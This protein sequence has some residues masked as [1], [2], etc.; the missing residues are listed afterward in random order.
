MIIAKKSHIE[1][2]MVQSFEERDPSIIGNDYIVVGTLDRSV[3]RKHRNTSTEAG[4]VVD[5][6][7]V[8]K[9]IKNFEI[10]PGW[11]YDPKK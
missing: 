4:K 8:F 1:D 5:D 6:I 2:M 10:M 3:W 9:D 7:Y 11:Y